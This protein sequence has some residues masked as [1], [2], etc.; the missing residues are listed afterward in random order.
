MFEA[1]QLGGKGMQNLGRRVGDLGG[2]SSVAL[3]AATAIGAVGIAAITVNA[4]LAAFAGELQNATEAAR[5]SARA[6]RLGLQ[7]RAAGNVPAAARNAA[8]EKLGLQNT[9]ERFKDATLR[10]AQRGMSKATIEDLISKAESA[11]ASGVGVSADRVLSAAAEG[12]GSLGAFSAGDR[13]AFAGRRLMA[14]GELAR[15]QKDAFLAAPSAARP[16]RGSIGAALVS[17]QHSER[18]GAVIQANR[19]AGEFKRGADVNY[20][21]IIAPG[22]RAIKEMIE[23]SNAKVRVLKAEADATWGVT[24]F[25]QDLLAQVGIGQGSKGLQAG[26]ELASQFGTISQP[27]GDRQ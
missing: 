16:E 7:D 13:Y 11:E 8:L 4:N 1:G 15:Q 24:M 2:V 21:E 6:A 10:L 22:T 5:G 26:R 25:M 17:A 18:A 14:A 20:L 3:G 19:F 9:P 27:L 12:R 23:V